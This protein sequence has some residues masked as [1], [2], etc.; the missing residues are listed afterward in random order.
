[1]FSSLPSSPTKDAKVVSP[2]FITEQRNFDPAFCVPYDLLKIV[3]L[4]T[5]SIFAH[6]HLPR[7][8]TPN[9]RLCLCPQQFSHRIPPQIHNIYDVITI[10]CSMKGALYILLS[11]PPQQ[12]PR[13][14]KVGTSLSFRWG[15][16][17]RRT[18]PKEEKLSF[19]IGYS[20]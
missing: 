12:C 1:M 11:N 15:N 16:V 2:A 13:W 20:Y 14:R 7:C 6:A 10:D 3:R 17:K 18:T 19:N 4:N 5:L 8:R 9:A